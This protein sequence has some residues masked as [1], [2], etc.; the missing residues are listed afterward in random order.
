M[1]R[2]DPRVEAARGALE[3][4]KGVSAGLVGLGTGS[5][6][7]EFISIASGWL[8]RASVVPSSVDTALELESRG[9]RPL[10]PRAV[11]GIDVYVD[12][13]DEVDPLGRMVKGGGGALL[14]EK[15][16]AYSSGFNVF[17]VGEDKL[18]EALGSRTPVPVEVSGGFAGLVV[19]A[20]RS[21]GFKA[22]YRVSPGKRGPLVSDWGGVIVDVYT[23][24][25]DDPERVD[26]ALRRIPGVVET[27]IF[28]GLA[29]AVVV[30]YR[31][32]GWEVLRFERRRGPSRIEG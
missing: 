18:V 21:L 27:G 14:G 28:I 15:V 25:M 19:S 1:P 9:L 8:S 31:E 11:G 20:L 23:G 10:D 24:P 17:I 6:V 29:D 13:A 5:T 7:R 26:E 3:L 2:C 16:M 12:G 32:C 4:L 22:E 30:G